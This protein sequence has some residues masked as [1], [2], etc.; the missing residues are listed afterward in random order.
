M[1]CKSCTASY[2]NTSQHIAHYPHSQ[3]LFQCLFPC[4]ALI[5]CPSL[6][7]SHA[8]L[9]M[10]SASVLCWICLCLCG[11]ILDFCFSD[12]L[13]FW[14]DLWEIL[15]L[16]IFVPCSFFCEFLNFLQIRE[17]RSGFTPFSRNLR[18]GW[19]FFPLPVLSAGLA[20]TKFAA[21]L[22]AP[23]G[24]AVHARTYTTRKTD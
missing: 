1:P 23:R 21:K 24:G 3:E 5:H 20:G 17:T 13:I 15:V 10:C 19:F 12:F 18:S 14:R 16:Y 9:R 7:K 8:P 6:P 2:H 22:A 11:L 4:L